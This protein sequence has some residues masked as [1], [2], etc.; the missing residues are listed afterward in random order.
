MVQLILIQQN[1]DCCQTVLKIEE[2]E[3][4]VFLYVFIILN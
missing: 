2:I 4:D 1:L 3:G